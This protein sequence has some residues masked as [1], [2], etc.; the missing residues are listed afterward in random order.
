MRAYFILT[1]FVL[2]FY[3]QLRANEVDWS[4]DYELPGKSSEKQTSFNRKNLYRLDPLSLEESIQKGRE[5]A[6]LYPVE[7]TQFFLPYD[8]L[9]RMLEVDVEG[10]LR[11]KLLSFANQFSPWENM[12]DL[13]Y[14]VGLSTYPEQPWQNFNIPEFS[15]SSEVQHMGVTLKNI[16]GA[17]G[18]TFSCAACHSAN[19]FGKRILGLQTR[20]PKANEAFH[21]AKN[22]FP[23]VN[24][25]MLTRFTE[26]NPAE[27]KLFKTTKKLLRYIGPKKPS[28]MG[29]DTSLAHTG[30]SLSKRLP[31][32]YASKDPLYALLPRYSPL[33]DKVAESK[34]GVWWNL[35][36]KTRWLLD[37]S[38]VSGN[39]VF[40]NF[41]WNEI[42]R[43]ADLKDLEAWLEKNSKTVQDLTAAVFA[44]E[45]PHYT[46]FFPAQSINLDSA[47][48]GE[49]LFNQSCAKCHGRYIK[50]WSH[51][52][53]KSLSLEEQLKTVQVYYSKKTKVID[54]GTDPLRYEGMKYFAKDLNRLEVSKKNNIL[55]VPQEGY[56]P[57][58]L[59]G[60]WLRWPYFH[61]NSAPSLCAVLTPGDRRPSKY[62]ALEANNPVT[63]FDQD[64]N[65]Y[66]PMEEISS[67]RKKDSAYLYD[68]TRAGL[69]NKGHD[70]KILL[71]ED[72]N[73]K[74]SGQ[75]KQDIITF[76]KTL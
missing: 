71:D 36:Y 63:D 70:K 62:Y 52:K 13:L 38:I 27:A 26:G 37:G 57:P 45:A 54:V 56:V 73:E 65:G 20:F 64:C 67:E 24:A 3:T 33:Q 31:D 10:P 46:D 11:K 35:K 39:P 29:L 47:K 58:P 50:G 69:S 44:T 34:P 25:N 53:V 8:M 12:E 41:I 7:T 5:H 49:K 61:N 55:V 48:R 16:N 21:M 2:F 72:G 60:I 30:L 66:P 42:G 75:D 22:L 17:T 14:W 19:I 23:L 68:S 4:R 32:G 43:G 51:Y 59:E 15:K 1:G 76:L 28:V 40:T 74:F 6:L 18:L 9:N